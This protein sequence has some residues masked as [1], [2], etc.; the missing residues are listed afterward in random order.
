[1]GKAVSS[2]LKYFVHDAALVE[3]EDIGERTRIW[4]FAHLLAGARVGADCNIGD[5]AFIE[6][7]ARLGNNVTVKN[8]VSVWSGVTVE[9]HCFLGPNC[10]FTNDLNPRAYLKKE[11]A[12]LV[13]TVV[14][15]GA[16]IG[17]NATVVCGH[18]IGRYAF[19]GA[20]AVVIR[21]VPDYA[22]VVGN[23]AR[24]TGWMCECA[25][26]LGLPAAAAVGD[27][28]TCRHCG[29]MYVRCASGLAR[30]PAS[31]QTGE[32]VR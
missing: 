24:H 5:H 1:M 12:S 10:V 6:G 7:G 9:D 4:A 3:T 23:P 28:C 31:A 32:E 26:R 14:K 2:G 18:S 11:P 27:T 15:T 25:T 20:G 13:P 19:V 21:D 22:L 17:A 30:Q 16:T 29:I 8:G